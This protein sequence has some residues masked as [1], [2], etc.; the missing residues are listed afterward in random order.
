LFIYILPVKSLR[1][2]DEMGNDGFMV[3]HKKVI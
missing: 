2:N 3:I 1:V